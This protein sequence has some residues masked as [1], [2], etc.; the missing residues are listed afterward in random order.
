MDK[1]KSPYRRMMPLLLAHSMLMN[2]I[3]MSSGRSDFHLPDIPE[4]ERIWVKLPKMK[5]HATK[6]RGNKLHDKNL[7][8]SKT[9][10]KI[11]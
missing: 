1:I 3:G 2:N 7:S 10:K 8:S 4:E 6:R 5:K 11:K 9:S